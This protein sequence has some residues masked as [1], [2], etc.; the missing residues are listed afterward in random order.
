LTHFERQMC[1]LWSVW[2]Q[3]HITGAHAVSAVAHFVPKLGTQ[4]RRCKQTDHF[5]SLG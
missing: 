4:M 2:A 1:L 3:G 5:E